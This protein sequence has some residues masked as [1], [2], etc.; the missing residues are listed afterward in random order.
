MYNFNLKS[1]K[2]DLDFIESRIIW[3]IDYRT[4]CPNIKESYEWLFHVY[5][6]SLDQILFSD[7]RE[8]YLMYEKILI[9]ILKKMLR[10]KSSL[11]IKIG[12]LKR[13]INIDLYCKLRRIIKK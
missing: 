5:K 12:I 11:K 2:V 3:A 9:D 6:V 10:D 13:I 7:D 4:M 1:N 8:K